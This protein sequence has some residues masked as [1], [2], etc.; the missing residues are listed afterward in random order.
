MAHESLGR[1]HSEP[2]NRGASANGHNEKSS[3][4][5][6]FGS[7]RVMRVHSG[8]WFDYDPLSLLVLF[9]G[10]GAVA[11]IAFTI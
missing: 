2:T 5:K 9:A 1:A 8:S 3:S 7:R 11:L 6:L 10:I 4:P